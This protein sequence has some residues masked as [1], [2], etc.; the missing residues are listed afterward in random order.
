VFSPYKGNKQVA[1]GDIFVT[2]KGGGVYYT[3]RRDLSLGWIAGLSFL[4]DADRSLH[5]AEAHPDAF[6]FAAQFD[7]RYFF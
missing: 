3:G 5:E 4:E 1:V 6:V 2:C 7:M